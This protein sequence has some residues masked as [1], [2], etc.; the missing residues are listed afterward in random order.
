MTTDHI[1]I[2]NGDKQIEKILEEADRLAQYESYGPKDTL[3]LRLLAEETIGMVRGITEDIEA[4]LWFEGDKD[5][6]KIHLNGKTNMS[7]SKFDEL[8]LM[9][10]TGKNTLAKGVMG[11]INE[12]IQL[13]FMSPGDLS[14]CAIINY[15]LLTPEDTMRDPTFAFQTLQSNMW[16]LKQYRESL[17][18]EKDSDQDNADAWDELEKSVVGNLADDVQIGINRDKVEVTIIRKLEHK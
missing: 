18:D 4:E 3:R 1:S 10:T 16:S 2:S 8:M 12:V 15:G 6:C 14:K 7:R 9:S 5:I 13:T 11:K 17:F